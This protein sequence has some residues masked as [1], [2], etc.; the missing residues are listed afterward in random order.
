VAD[1]Q[2]VDATA[3]SGILPRKRLTLIAI[4]G[5]TFM[6]L[7]DVTIVQVALPSLQRE[8]HVGFTSLQW[9]IDAYALALAALILASGSL[10][11]RLGRKRVFVGG[12]VVFTAASL[13]C[14]LST[15]A[16]SVNL[17]RAVQGI[18]GAAMFATALALI[19]QE[20]TGP[21]RGRAIALWG[22]TVGAAVAM[23]PLL[24]GALTEWFGWRWVFFVNL[25]IG[26]AVVVIA[27]RT[28]RNVRDPEATSTD[29][30]GLLLF[31]SSFALL[32]FSLLRGTGEGWSSPMILATFAGSAVGL[33]AFVA[34][35]R[36]QERPMLDLSLF[37]N[38]AF[39]GVS[40]ATVTIGAGMFAVVPFLTLYLQNI[41]DFSPLQGGVRLLPIFLLTF[42]VPVVAHSRLTRIPEGLTLAAGLGLVVVGLLLMHGQSAGSNWISLLPGMVIAGGG[43]GLANPAIAHIALAVVPPQRVGMASGISN[44][45]RLGGLAIGV[46]GLG[47]LLQSRI[48][49]RL[50]DVLPNQPAGLANAIASGGTHG[51]LQVAHGPSATIVE[52][53]RIAFVSGLNVILLVGACALAVGTLATLALVRPSTLGPR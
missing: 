15:N 26:V 37:R 7:V 31:S 46:A 3:S 52:G 2:P 36:Y 24:G 18:G 43:I 19:G 21:A 38:P 42:F 51:A 6:L 16:L 45:F 27:S 47:A 53:S 41:L 32:I 11:D 40:L 25:P 12:V 1:L 5:A 30:V 48:A 14:G 13:A 9:V 29:I 44:T 50:P 4:L 49:S 34:V 8:L 17:G 22:A 35:E 28:M 20:F 39:C 33:I 23:G 10:A